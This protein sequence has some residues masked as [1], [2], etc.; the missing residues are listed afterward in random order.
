MPDAKPFLRA[1]AGAGLG[2]HAAE[3]SAVAVHAPGAAA[4]QVVVDRCDLVLHAH[5][6]VLH[7]G[8]EQPGQ[9]EVDQPVHTSERQRRLG[10]LTG[11]HIHARPWPPAWTIPSTSPRRIPP[12]PRPSLPD[13]GRTSPHPPEGGGLIQLCAT[14]RVD[15]GARLEPVLG[16]RLATHLAGAVGALCKALPRA[17]Y[18]L[19]DG[20]QVLL[21][22]HG[23]QPVDG[24]RGPLP[25]ALAERDGPELARRFGELGQLR[26]E[27]CLALGEQPPCVLVHPV[28]VRRPSGEP[29]RLRPD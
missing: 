27:L 13:L 10:A 4:G 2:H 15:Q 12:P 19:E 29:L 26:L 20:Q 22:R 23:G 25:D 28:R 21:G 9:G 6:D 7:L 1:R 17:A 14:Q 5:P 8:V 18:F 24:H 11:E 3:A 16:D